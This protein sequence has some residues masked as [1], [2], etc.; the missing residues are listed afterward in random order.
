MVTQ[1]ASTCPV[2]WEKGVGGHARSFNVPGTVRKK[3]RWSCKSLQ[4]ARFSEKKDEGGHARSFNVPG[5]VVKRM[6]VVTQAAP[7][8]PV[9]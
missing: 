3:M 6:R 5:T 1:V 8:F 4:C 2:Q 9:Q 7:T